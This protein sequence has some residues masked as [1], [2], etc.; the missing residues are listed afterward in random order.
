[1]PLVY[2]RDRVRRLR[3]V[4][5][6]GVVAGLLLALL[7]VFTVVSDESLRRFGVVVGAAGALVVGL[8]VASV[9]ALNARDGRA[10]VIASVTGAAT[11]LV[12]FLF[13]KTILGFAMIVLGIT[14]LLLARLRDDPDL[15]A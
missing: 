10:K 4:L 11:M 12:G 13:A 5:N 9:R 14:I 2:S 15:D 1:M 8:C 3:L 6:V 7:A